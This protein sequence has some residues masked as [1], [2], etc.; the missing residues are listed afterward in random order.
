MYLLLLSSRV[1]LIVI[2]RTLSISLAGIDS[3]TGLD[4]RDIS[5]WWTQRENMAA[6]QPQVSRQEVGMALY[7]HNEMVMKKDL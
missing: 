3:A 2:S 7:V 5:T 4:S 1:N 6:E